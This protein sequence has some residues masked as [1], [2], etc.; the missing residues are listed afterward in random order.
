MNMI[1][2]DFKFFEPINSLVDEL[3]QEGLLNNK[4]IEYGLSLMEAIQLFDRNNGIIRLKEVGSYY[5]FCI[6]KAVFLDKLL[7]LMNYIAKKFPN[8]FDKNA[9]LSS[10]LK[11]VLYLNVNVSY[12][13]EGVVYVEWVFNNEG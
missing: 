13:K 3:K 11:A 4:D 2:K 1:S 8:N 9:V 5:T 12:E 7:N 10:F 6:D